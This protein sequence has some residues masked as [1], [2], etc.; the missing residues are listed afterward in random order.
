MKTFLTAGFLFALAIFAMPATAQTPAERS[1][2]TAV[3]ISPGELTPTPQM[4]FYEQYRREY[5]D[6]KE[7][8]HNRAV[9][10]AEQRERRI[11]TMKWLGLSKARPQA[12][13]DPWDA[14]VLPAW[15]AH[16]LFYPLG[17]RASGASAV[18]VQHDGSIV[19]AY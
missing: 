2:S 17:F 5:Q 1:L 16:Y 11:A 12:A 7:A 10:Q 19:P 3:T 13:V 15:K 9:F 18:V 6:P 8:I 14:P 4:W